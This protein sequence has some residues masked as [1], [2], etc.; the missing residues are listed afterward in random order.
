MVIIAAT[1]RHMLT[2]LRILLYYL[3]EPDPYCEEP[4]VYSQRA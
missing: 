2:L 3:A 1:N 4:N